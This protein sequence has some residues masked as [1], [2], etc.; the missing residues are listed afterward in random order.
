V[1]GALD[2]AARDAVRLLEAR[3]ELVVIEEY[4]TDA[5]PCG[6]CRNHG[7]FRP[8]PASRIV[9]IL[10]YCLPTRPAQP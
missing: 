9:E 10:G 2:D 3:R 7:P 8:A 1:P 5:A 4:S 6:R